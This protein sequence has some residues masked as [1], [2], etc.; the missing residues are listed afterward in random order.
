[1][2]RST[3]RFPDPTAKPAYVGVNLGASHIGIGQDP[4]ASP[5]GR[6]VSLWLYTDDCDGLVEEL[7]AAGT[8]ILEVP[9]D[10]RWGERVAKV[11]DP[12]GIVVHVANRAASSTG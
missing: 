11:E 12:N 1:M 10:Q 9:R 7:R 5:R 4:A 6:T 3:S 2:A 8:P